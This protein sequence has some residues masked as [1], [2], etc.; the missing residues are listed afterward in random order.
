MRRSAPLRSPVRTRE[1]R[2]AAKARRAS[3]AEVRATLEAFYR[4]TP[5]ETAPPPAVAPPIRVAPVELRQVNAGPR[6]LVE[7]IDKR[8][9]IIS[10]RYLDAVRALS[11]AFCPAPAPVNP[12]HVERTGME[13]RRNDLSA[14]P[15][16]G[17][18]STGCHGDCH[19]GRISPDRQEQAVAETQARLFEQRGA[20]WWL[21]V[22]REIGEGLEK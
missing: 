6:E 21:G 4:G 11:C 5:L 15:A 22:M 17:G 19:N 14:V 1:E 2:A 3:R 13:Q 8:A 10:D 9:E 16:C 18:G 12:H 7:P 20:L